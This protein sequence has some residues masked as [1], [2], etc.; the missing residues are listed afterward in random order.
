METVYYGRY[1]FYDTG[2]WRI[3]FRPNA[4]VP[5]S[6]RYGQVSKLKSNPFSIWR[7]GR[8]PAGRMSR[9]QNNK[10]RWSK[11]FFLF[12]RSKLKTGF[13]AKFLSCIHARDLAVRLSNSAS[14]LR[15]LKCILA[16]KSVWC[17]F[18]CNGKRS[19]TFKNALTIEQW[20]LDT[21]AGKQLS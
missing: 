13:V 7:F 20:I 8:M 16:A 19:S 9:R 17:V 2:P 3:I 15:Q 1:T 11:V 14:L 12:W 4:A 6:S 18:R 21:N 5:A 10:K